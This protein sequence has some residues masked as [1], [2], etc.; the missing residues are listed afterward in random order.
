[1][2]QVNDI[3]L[4]QKGV[5]NSIWPDLFTIYLACFNYSNLASIK[6]RCRNMCHDLHCK[7]NDSVNYLYTT[8]EKDRAYNLRHSK[9]GTVRSC[10][11]LAN[12]D[13]V[14]FQ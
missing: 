13:F 1:M 12:G 10:V 9:T 5:L 14:K 4:V 11:K 8:F 6:E 2:M 7:I 3:K